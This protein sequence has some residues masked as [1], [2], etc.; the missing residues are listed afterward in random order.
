M[1]QLLAAHQPSAPS[2]PDL[3]PHTPGMKNG[4]LLDYQ[5]NGIDGFEL[6][7]VEP[8]AGRQPST[9]VRGFCQCT[10]R[11]CFRSSVLLY[12]CTFA[13]HGVAN[14][15]ITIPHGADPV[16]GFLTDT[17]RLH[18]HLAKFS[19]I[20]QNILLYFSKCYNF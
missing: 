14:T 2:N 6:V 13:E 5:P 1:G 7:V 9:R 16:K 10:C 20:N 11:H 12:P 18:I 19:I 3:P 15:K 4:R 8:S 17:V